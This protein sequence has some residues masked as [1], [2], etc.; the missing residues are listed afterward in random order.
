MIMVKNVTPVSVLRWDP[1]SVN[2]H[3]SILYTKQTTNYY[4][5]LKCIMV[6]ISVGHRRYSPHTRIDIAI[7]KKVQSKFDG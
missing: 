5:L 2:I 1:A 3:N 6:I 4:F 7:M